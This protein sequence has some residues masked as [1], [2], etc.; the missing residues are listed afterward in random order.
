MRVEITERQES[1]VSTRWCLALLLL[2]LYPTGMF[3]VSG[4]T[5]SVKSNPFERLSFVY[6]DVGSSWDMMV[7]RCNV[8]PTSVKRHRTSDRQ[9]ISRP[10]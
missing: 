8:I 10:M 7:S 4:T 1:V 3:P 6:R 2:L 9:E 5:L